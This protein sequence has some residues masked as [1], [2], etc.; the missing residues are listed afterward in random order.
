MNSVTKLFGIGFCLFYAARLLASQLLIDSSENQNVFLGEETNGIRARINLD[1]ANNLL[2]SAH[3]QIK[4]DTNMHSMSFQAAE[5]SK[6]DPSG[7]GWKFFMA[8]NLFSGPMELSDSAGH[9]MQ[10]LNPDCTFPEMWPHKYHLFAIS[11]GL[12]DKHRIYSGPSMPLPLSLSDMQIFSFHLAD[13]YK[14]KEPGNY[15]L[16]IWPK[17]YQRVSPTNDI[18]ERIDIPPVTIDLK[19]RRDM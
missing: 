14:I 9:K 15:K 2:I 7:H 3:V 18:C 4:L 10:S 6:R 5:L 11:A 17:I 1:V 13:Y 8:T 12:I 16:T 19:C